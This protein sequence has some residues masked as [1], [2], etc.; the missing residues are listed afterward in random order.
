MSIMIELAEKGVFPDPLIRW[1]VKNL[2]KERLLEAQHEATGNHFNSLG[3]FVDSMREASIA[4]VPEL[5]NEQHYEVPE[6]FFG[7][8][9]GKHR[10]YSSC[11][12]ENSNTPLDE[13]ETAMLT[14]SCQRAQIENGMSILELGCGWGSLSLWMAEQ[15]PDSSVLSVSNSSSQ[16]AY[17]D[18]QAESRGLKNLTVITC[19][20]NDFEPEG[21]FDR[22][23]SIEM[24]EHMKNWELLIGK[25]ENVMTENAKLFLHVFSHRI[26]AYHFLKENDDEWMAQHF[27]SGGMMPSH[28]IFDRLDVPLSL[29]SSWFVN[30]THYQRTSDHWL[31]HM[32]TRKAEIMPI[33]QSTYGSRLAKV[34]FQRWKIFFIAC[35]ELFGYQ[36]CQQWGVSHFLLKK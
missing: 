24:F 4:E 5:A 8:V 19:D 36:N 34:W 22:I 32:N 10:K 9:L 35:S 3:R 27:F 18:S 7:E 29:E 25:L 16:K 1:G 14:L 20:M 15:Y 21:Q 13:A 23:I 2:V 28:H 26:Y 6:V 17:I 12:Y 30:G 33:L 11:Y 31:E